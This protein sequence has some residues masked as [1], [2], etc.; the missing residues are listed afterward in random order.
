MKQEANRDGKKK[1]ERRLGSDRL[2]LAVIKASLRLFE[3][4]LSFQMAPV[5]HW[6]VLPSEGVLTN[7]CRG[8]IS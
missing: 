8:D 6:V 5:L 1:P 3:D 4:E 7:D 2:G